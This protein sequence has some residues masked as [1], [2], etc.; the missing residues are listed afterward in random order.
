MG[1]TRRYVFGVAGVVVVVRGGCMCMYTHAFANQQVHMKHTYMHIHPH[2]T[3]VHRHPITH[4]HTLSHTQISLDTKNV[5]IECTA[6]DLTKAEIVLQTVCAMFSQHCS[7]PFTME[8]VEVVDATGAV[9]GMPIVI[10]VVLLLL[11]HCYLCI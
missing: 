6:T 2:H 5:L 3:H 4:T 7:Q 8:P 1:N 11:S 10:I 9:R